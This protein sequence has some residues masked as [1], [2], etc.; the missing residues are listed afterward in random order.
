MV[1]LSVLYVEIGSFSPMRFEV[2]VIADSFAENAAANSFKVSRVS[3]ALF[4][5]S[6]ITVFTNSVVAIW[7]V[8]VLD[9]AVGAS[10]IPVK[11]GEIFGALFDSNVAIFS[12]WVV[13]LVCSANI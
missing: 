3:G 2:V 10:G 7:V 8:F 5:N 6:S 9:I 12:S 11:V 1:V 4:I 13:S